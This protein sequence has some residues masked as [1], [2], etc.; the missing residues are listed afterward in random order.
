MRITKKDKE[1]LR[2]SVNNF[3]SKIN[4]TI[5]KGGADAYDIMPNNRSVKDYNLETMDRKEFNREIKRM[6]DFS[7][8][9]NSTNIKTNKYGVSITQW[10][11][12]VMKSNARIT[13]NERKKELER[14][15]N[16]HII[17]QGKKEQQT[18]KEYGSHELLHLKPIKFNFDAIQR[19][20]SFDRF[21]KGLAEKV[22]STYSATRM[23]NYRE[24]FISG[25]YNQLSVYAPEMIDMIMQ[26]PLEK[27]SEL[28]YTSLQGNIDWL[29]DLSTVEERA[30]LLR[31][32]LV[33]E[34][35]AT[36]NGELLDD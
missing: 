2:K 7:S 10:E 21:A 31:D 23:E 20:S 5:K 34:G 14:I 27:L 17:N 15:E 18:V 1:K 29:Y 3:N 24:S 12:N 25:I 13:N 32:T 11:Y 6:K 35:G 19:K 4:R 16:I 8:K 26:V 30:K 28:I 9:K 33:I 22:K 36:Y